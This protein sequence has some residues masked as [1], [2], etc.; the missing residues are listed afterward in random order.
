[1]A[2]SPYIRPPRNPHFSED[3]ESPGAAPMTP[4]ER[5]E[6]RDTTW[7]T[8]TPGRVTGRKPPPPS[9]WGGWQG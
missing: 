4:I 6:P 7:D 3:V 9:D 2:G 8:G 1:M 5:G